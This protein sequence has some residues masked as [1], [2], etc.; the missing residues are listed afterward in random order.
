V[1]V[2]HAETAKVPANGLP[3]NFTLHAMM[4]PVLSYIA[5]PAINTITRI[6]MII[7]ERVQ[8]KDIP[9]DSPLLAVFAISSRN[10]PYAVKCTVPCCA[11][12]N[13]RCKEC[14]GTNTCQNCKGTGYRP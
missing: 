7:A 9:H 6:L 5:R 3:E 13:H 1:E 8:E 2:K 4:A 14:G 12:K 11:S 10:G